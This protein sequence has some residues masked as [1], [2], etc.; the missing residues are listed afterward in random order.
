MKLSNKILIWFF[1][2]A[3]AYMSL[4][5]TEIRFRAP[6]Q[7][8]DNFTAMDVVSL[9]SVQNLV[10]NDLDNRVYVTTADDPRIELKSDEKL[11][12]KLDYSI[13]GKTLSL[14]SID[15]DEE[16]HFDLTIY[17]PRDFSTMEVRD[18]WVQV[19]GVKQSNLALIQNGGRTTLS[20]DVDLENL[21][22]TLTE[23]AEIDAFG[24]RIERV[25]VDSD[26]SN[27]ELRTYVGRIEGQMSNRSYLYLQGTDELNFKKDKSSSMR[28]LQ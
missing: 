19:S 13:D 4:A 1:G 9:D 16:K 5:F 17:M 12:S 18:G 24:S 8:S 11:L 3:V 28:L 25:I 15:L 2:G 7:G 6:K 23:N 22:L 21:S 27:I 10:I 26:F 14:N 20:K